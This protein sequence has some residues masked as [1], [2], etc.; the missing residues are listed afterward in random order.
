MAVIDLR[1]DAGAATVKDLTGT[2]H[3]AIE[4]DVSSSESVS[5]AFSAVDDAFKRIDILVNNAGIDRAEGDGFDEMMQGA[6][7]LI[8][9]SDE[10]FRRVMAVNV[11]SVFLCTR[12][13]VCRMQRDGTAGSIVNMS[14]IAGISGQ[15]VPHY[16]ASKAAVLGF[17]RSTARQLGRIGIRVNAV[18][19]GVID[20]PMTSEVPEQAVK[21]L[22]A[23]T[24]LGRMGQPE[25][26]AQ[27]V[28]Y[29]AGDES[30]FVT[31]QWLSPNG[32][33]VTC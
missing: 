4:A 17:T 21:G 31:G 9:M 12:Q 32:G 13:A 5:E 23:A 3:I 6:Q 2:G 27:A 25:E 1:R 16:A 11:D 30:S 10:A 18:C 15:G 33:L 28:L 19:P 26:I 24:P 7:Q 8:H 20:T 29:L 22:L 14:S